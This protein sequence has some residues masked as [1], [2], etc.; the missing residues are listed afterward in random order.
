[1]AVTVYT[2]EDCSYCKKAKELLIGHDIPF[3]EIIVSDASSLKDL[4]KV[5]KSKSRQIT[6]PQVYFGNVCIGG[7]EHL[8]DKLEEPLLKE[9]PLRFSPFPI[10]HSDM[11]DMYKKSVASFWTAEEIDF[12][13]DRDD[14]DLKLKPQERHF[15]KHVLAFFASADGIVQENLAQNFL[16]DVQVP[17]A[18]MFYSY[19]I[20][21]EA[22]HNQTYG[23]LIDAYIDDAAEKKHLFEAIRTIPCVQ[24][25]AEWALMWTDKSKTFA[26]RLVAFVCVEGLLFSGSFCAIFWLKK[27]GLMPSLAFSNELI[28]RDEGLHQNFGTLLYTKYLKHKLPASR[29]ISIVR[30]AVEHE[31]EFITEAVPC[32]LIGMNADL[33]KQYIRFV[34]DTIIVSLGYPAV[35]KVSNPFDFMINICLQGKTNF[36]ERRVSEYQRSCI[37]ANQEDCVFGLDDEF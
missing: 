17:E 25:K 28:S 8:R 14:W 3:R 12:S 5:Q 19:Q 23:M 22:I 35:Y 13:K 9:N 36:F 21:N 6:F 18:R 1:M 31:E 24:K 7:Y 26:E 29:V 15:V 27:R 20:F 34:A 30:E 16:N 2:K 11:Y 10:E 37:M 32:A 33:L 4:V